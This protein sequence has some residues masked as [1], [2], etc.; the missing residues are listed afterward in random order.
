MVYFKHKIKRIAQP[1]MTT[2][3]APLRGFLRHYLLS[4]TALILGLSQNTFAQLP[5]GQQT[6]INL[7][8]NLVI[9][10]SPPIAKK[11]G[12]ESH[13][14]MG[15]FTLADGSSYQLA[16]IPETAPLY[17]IER[18]GELQ[19]SRRPRSTDVLE[20]IQTPFSFFIVFPDSRRIVLLHPKNNA[21]A[22]HIF[23]IGAMTDSVLMLKKSSPLKE[24]PLEVTQDLAGYD[25]SEKRNPPTISLEIN[26]LVERVRGNKIILDLYLPDFIMPNLAERIVSKGLKTN[27]FLNVTRDSEITFPLEGG[28]VYTTQNP[29]TKDLEKLVNLDIVATIYLPQKKGD[30]QLIE[31]SPAVL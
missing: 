3:Q 23:E 21:Y 29:N 18:N 7:I 25:F 15:Q 26:G 22:A 27:V 14:F 17:T 5:Q 19:S 6:V 31:L 8:E 10:P 24:L 30:V 11:R 9:I 28:G 16:Q 1:T 13:L 20:S 12:T 4:L 2:R